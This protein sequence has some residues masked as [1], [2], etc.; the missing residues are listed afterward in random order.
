MAS[1]LF[2]GRHHI[3]TKFQRQYLKKLIDEG[4]S[5]KKVDRIVFAVTSSNHENTRRNPIPLYLRAM[6]ISRFSQELSCEVKIYPIPDIL[7]SNKFAKFTLSQIFYQSGEKLTPENTIL[8]CST[9]SVIKLF[10]ELGFK[11]M[12]VELDEKKEKYSTPRPW[13]V[14]EMIAKAGKNWKT[15]KKWKEYAAEASQDI[16]I[17]YNLGDLIVEL[18][19]DSLL[20]EDADITDTRNYNTYATGM[21]KNVEFKFNDIRP[22]IVEGKIVDA[23]CGTGA[24]VNLLAKNFPES[25]IIGIEATRKFYEFC[26]MQ[27]YANPFVFF[28]RRNV[29]DQNFKENTINSFIYSSILHEIYSYMGEKRLHKLLK[30]TY[31]QLTIGGRII[32]RD[33]VGPENL[34]EMI[35]MKLNDKD[36]KKEGNIKELSTYSKFFRFAKD[37]VR[38][39]KFKKVNLEG[40]NLIQLKLAD[41]YEYISKMSYTD[42]WQSEMHEQFGFYSFSKWKKVLEAAGFAIVEGSKPFKNDYIIEKNYKGKA[43]LYKKKGKSLVEIDYPPTNMI[44][45]GE[46][47]I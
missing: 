31:N 30:N 4:I 38:K 39:I 34:N 6:A 9:P 32:I 27:D 1:I 45:A 24:L 29:L 35:F 19:S 20:T 11:N 46:K 2:P 18:F 47:T 16:Y 17:E 43:T 14:V 5:G 23:G 22:F 42:N 40:K 12:P 44:L 13:E 21:D 8:A 33:V 26:K 3:L 41:A 10:Q 7:N 28:Y 25:D 37:F 36:G 15:D